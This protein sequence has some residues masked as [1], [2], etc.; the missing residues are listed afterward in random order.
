MNLQF[1]KSLRQKFLNAN[2]N[3]WM[4]I[5]FIHLRALE[6]HATFASEFLRRAI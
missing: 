5:S 3:A 6:T 1:I 4:P 2:S